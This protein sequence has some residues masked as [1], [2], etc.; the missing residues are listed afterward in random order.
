MSSEGA[1]LVLPRESLRKPAVLAGLTGS[2]ERSILGTVDSTEF[3]AKE[4]DK[5][6]NK[7]HPGQ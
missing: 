3:C 5:Y 7:D 1:P 6:G 2:S 4:R